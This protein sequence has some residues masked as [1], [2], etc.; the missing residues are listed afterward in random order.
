MRHQQGM[1]EKKQQLF[2]RTCVKFLAGEKVNPSK[3]L[4][5]FHRMQFE[6]LDRRLELTSTF[7]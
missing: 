6:L 1:F 2:F 3:V 7:Y 5:K 4:V